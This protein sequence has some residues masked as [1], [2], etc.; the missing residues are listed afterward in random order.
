V[1]LEE[2]VLFLVGNYDLSAF[3]IKKGKPEKPVVYFLLC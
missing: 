1:S 3:E 2:A